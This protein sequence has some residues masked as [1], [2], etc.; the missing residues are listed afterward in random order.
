MSGVAGAIAGGLLIDA[1]HLVDYGWTWLT[2]E[3]RHFFAPLHG[4]ELS[5][6]LALGAW[7]AER[8]AKK[9]D[10]LP[11][12]WAP[13]LSF[14]GERLGADQLRRGAGLLAGL[15]AGSGVHLLHDLVSNRPAHAGAYSLLFRVW[16]RFERNAVGWS[17][18]P[19]FH[20]WSGKP[21]YHWF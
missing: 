7:W 1:D 10:V 13:R 16:H 20:G 14:V 6:A 18:H 19:D 8:E 2:G 11:D 3:R 5:L 12:C 17:E 9:A 4:W 15:A 21:W